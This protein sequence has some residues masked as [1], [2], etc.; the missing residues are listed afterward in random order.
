MN[1]LSK[2][3][4]PNMNY[5]SSNRFAYTMISRNYYSCMHTIPT[6]IF[7]IRDTLV[8]LRIKKYKTFLIVHAVC[9]CVIMYDWDNKEL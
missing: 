9:F 3:T 5:K 4:P 1:Q 6:C 7:H 2:Y 8:R